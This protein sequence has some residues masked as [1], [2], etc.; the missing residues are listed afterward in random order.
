MNY[1]FKMVGA[2]LT[3][4]KAPLSVTAN[5]LSSVY[6]G[7]IPTPGYTITG[8]ANGDTAATAVTGAPTLSMTATTKSPAGQYPI[9]IAKG[10]LVAANYSFVLVNGTLTIGKAPLNVSVGGLSSVYGQPLPV[11][12]NDY[13]LSGFVNGDTAATS[14]S[15]VPSLATT[16]TITSPVG[17][18]PITASAGGLVS[19]NYSFSFAPGLLSIT[20]A[21]LTVAAINQTMVA[22]SQ[23]PILSF[24]L[25]G[26]AADESLSGALTGAPVLTT[27]ATSGSGAGTY[28]ITVAIG[29]LAATNYSFKL[30]NG[31]LTVTAGGTAPAS[32]TEVGRGTAIPGVVVYYTVNG[33][34]RKVEYQR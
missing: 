7:A 14:V 4:T 17:G 16:A 30:V 19:A 20:K 11:L 28:P 26:F 3:V 12:T 18:Y 15:G 29:T 1:S 10:T 25:S 9:S 33:A 5:N 6:G 21:V 23:V 27:T 22:G 24:S 34:I 31:T 32:N 2:T 13:S 8:F